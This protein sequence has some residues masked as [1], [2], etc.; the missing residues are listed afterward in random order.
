MLLRMS[1]PGGSVIEQ[2]MDDCAVLFRQKAHSNFE[3]ALTKKMG[4]WYVPT[5]TFVIS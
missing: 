1:T 3:R 4:D 5:A 2:N